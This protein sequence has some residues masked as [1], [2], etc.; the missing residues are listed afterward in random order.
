MAEDVVDGMVSGII[1]KV[2]RQGRGLRT[3][4]HNP[5]WTCGAMKPDAT[6]PGFEPG[7][8]EPK[9]LVLPLHYGV[10]RLKKGQFS[11]AKEAEGEE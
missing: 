10:V 4:G 7:Q 2:Y 6:P 8:R 3:V 1:D 11:A 5:A 9:S